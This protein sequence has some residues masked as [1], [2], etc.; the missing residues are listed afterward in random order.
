LVRQTNLDGSEHSYD[1]RL[2]EWDM[3]TFIMFASDVLHNA[4]AALDNLAYRLSELNQERLGQAITDEKAGDIY[5]P[6]CGNAHNFSS[7]AGSALPLV[8][9]NARKLIRGY[10][11]YNRPDPIETDGVPL[12][13]GLRQLQN[14]DK[15]RFLVNLGFEFGGLRADAFPGHTIAMTPGEALRAV[16]GPQDGMHFCTFTVDPPNPDLDLKP[17]PAIFICF[18]K[19]PWDRR[20]VGLVLWR[21][22]DAIADLYRDARSLPEC[23]AAEG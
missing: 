21:L 13:W 14:V 11:P 8:S 15:H 4:R 22:L 20:H 23:V 12:F 10:Q 17:D 3:D 6:I 19:G 16:N 7:E 1:L 2:P 5:F 9:R 18:D